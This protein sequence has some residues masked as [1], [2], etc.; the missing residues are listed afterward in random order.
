MSDDKLIMKAVCSACFAL[1][2]LTNTD[3]SSAFAHVIA[4]TTCAFCGIL[5]G[6]S[7]AEQYQAAF[8]IGKVA[9]KAIN[10][11]SKNVRENIVDKLT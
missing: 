7:S 1:E 2:A 3:N 6:K 8:K 11:A 10:V 5:V 9:A 4:G